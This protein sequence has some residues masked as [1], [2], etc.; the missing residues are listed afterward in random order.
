MNFYSKKKKKV[1][2]RAPI[3]KSEL[4]IFFPEPS[5]IIPEKQLE[6]ILAA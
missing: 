2:K 4:I 6:K 1:N 5:E 3:L